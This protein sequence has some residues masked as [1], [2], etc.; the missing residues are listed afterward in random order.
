VSSA[1]GIR[2]VRDAAARAEREAF[3]AFAFAAASHALAA[4]RASSVLAG[5][6]SEEALVDAPHLDAA[7][8]ALPRP[9]R[10]LSAHSNDG[11]QPGAAEVSPALTVLLPVLYKSAA[12][13]RLLVAREA[14][15]GDAELAEPAAWARCAGPVLEQCAAHVRHAGAFAWPLLWVSADEMRAF[16][17]LVSANGS[18]GSLRSP[19][20]PGTPAR[21][22]SLRKPITPLGARKAILLVCTRP[23]R[24]GRAAGHG[25]ARSG[26][27]PRSQPS[28][29]FPVTSR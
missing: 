16:L 11:A 10:F 8:G 6:L 1:G 20:T 15:A 27:W 22:R 4:V 3:G 29:C 18:N 25:G 23:P 12:L 13:L 9:E 7:A 19:A 17:A 26:T 21:R 24:P 2:Q 28:R 14:E 5:E